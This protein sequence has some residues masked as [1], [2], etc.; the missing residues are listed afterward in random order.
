MEHDRGA[1][2]RERKR[3]GVSVAIGIG[4]RKMI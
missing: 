4:T 2:R 3:E 1:L